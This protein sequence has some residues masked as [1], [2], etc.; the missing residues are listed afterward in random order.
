MYPKEFVAKEFVATVI[1]KQKLVDARID[2]VRQAGGRWNKAL[3]DLEQVK[4]KKGEPKNL[5]QNYL[6]PLCFFIKEKFGIWIEALGGSEKRF[7]DLKDAVAEA[8]AEWNEEM[9]RKRGVEQELNNYI[10]QYLRTTSLLHQRRSEVAEAIREIDEIAEAFYRE[11]TDIRCNLIGFETPEEFEKIR[12]AGMKRMRVLLPKTIKDLAP[13]EKYV[14]E[15]AD[16]EMVAPFS[17]W[18]TSLFSRL[19]SCPLESEN[20]EDTKKELDAIL[21]IMR[22]MTNGT[23]NCDMP[24]EK[25]LAQRIKKTKELVLRQAA[26]S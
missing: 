9:M 16:D 2:Q 11:T 15:R 5:S 18:F 21:E 4:G 20:M 7:K 13:W 8:Q 25:W 26:E 1:A 10:D 17:Q 12:A 6:L 19:R 3:D 23:R 22:R 14:S 24:I